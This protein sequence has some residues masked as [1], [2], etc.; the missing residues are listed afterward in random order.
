MEEHIVRFLRFLNEDRGLTPN[1]V[2]A[3][4]NDLRQFEE[5]LHGRAP[6]GN[7]NGHV[8]LDANRD[9]AGLLGAAD[10]STVTDFV[11]GLR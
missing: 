11:L 10:R 6:N 2:A 9:G 3:Y 1:T 5:Y 8:A 7:G 4:Q